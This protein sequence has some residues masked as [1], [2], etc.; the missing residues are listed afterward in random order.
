[1]SGD[2][3]VMMRGLFDGISNAAQIIR[4]AD[5]RDRRMQREDQAYQQQQSERSHALK[6]RGIKEQR[7]DEAYERGETD[8]LRKNEAMQALNAFMINND[9]ETANA[10][11]D[12]YSPE[13]IKP[14]IVLN[15][16]G[17]YS[18]VGKDASG[19]DVVNKLERD[20]IGKL[21]MRMGNQDVFS[22]YQ[23][24]LDAKAAGK[25][26]ALDREH[27][28]NK[29]RL[30]NAGKIKAAAV[31]AGGKA[32]NGKVPGWEKNIQTLAKNHY[33]KT[34]D[35][36][37]WSYEEGQ[38]ALSASHMSLARQFYLS[39]PDGKRNP[40]DAH[41]KAVRYI[42][43]I[44][45][46]SEKAAI[47]EFE[48]G[49]INEEDVASFAAQVLSNTVNEQLDKVSSGKAT[50][51]KSSAAKSDKPE[52]TAES[53]YQYLKKQHPDR[54]DK[55]IKARVKEMFP[56]YSVTSEEQSGDVTPKKVADAS[57]KTKDKPAMPA[58]PVLTRSRVKQDG[59]YLGKG[60][61]QMV[62][63]ISNY[64]A[65]RAAKPIIEAL[66]KGRDPTES[67][68]KAWMYRMRRLGIKPSDYPKEIA[69]LA[70]KKNKNIALK[71][72]NK[73]GSEI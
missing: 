50:K 23:K 70:K 32:G 28:L 72:N 60:I 22:Q 18:S 69:S 26:K 11:L 36:G 39:M 25:A 61:D 59:P 45:D 71:R 52:Q 49:N 40:T 42:E 64:K 41:R 8:R 46:R 6:R 73:E 14:N 63:A 56:E 35:N 65:K 38:N 17:S 53:Y 44:A 5:D 66:K 9:I 2:N 62:S 68:I 67:E 10:F 37:L 47:A 3:A 57:P 27:D 7:E 20:D 31:K 51:E 55:A 54:S 1:M 48:A 24:D 4:N 16:D 29:I 15:E 30:D 58:E 34:Y 12:K 33:G 43:N 13:N 21:L 19:K